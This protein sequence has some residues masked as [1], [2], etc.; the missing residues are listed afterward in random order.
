[1]GVVFGTSLDNMTFLAIGIPM[2]MVVGIAIGS[3]MDKKAF[4]ENRQLDLEF[5]Y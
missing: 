4:E 2:G 3:T 5:K 1:M